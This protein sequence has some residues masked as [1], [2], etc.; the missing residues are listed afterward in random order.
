MST[1]LSPSADRKS[2]PLSIVGRLVLGVLA[3][4]AVYTVLWVGAA[5]LLR[6]QAEKWLDA[7]RGEGVEVAYHEPTLNGFP[8]QVI[9][10]FPDF[11]ATISGVNS[12][13]TWHTAA[14]R[15]KGNPLRAD[16]LSLDLAGVHSITG[17]GPLPGIPLQLAASQADLMLEIGSDGRLTRAQLEASAA[18]AAWENMPTLMQLEQAAVA[19]DLAAEQPEVS[20]RLSADL[21]N[22]ALPGLALPPL[23]S[24]MRRLH[25]IADIQGPVGH[26]ALPQVLEAW[27]TAGGT[28]EFREFALDW[29]PLSVDGSGTIALDGDLQPMGVFTA[30]FRGFFDTIDVL[31]E[32]QL[33]RSADAAMARIVLGL[34]ARSPPGGGPP[35]L[36]LAVTAQDRKLY[37]GPITLM[38]IPRLTWPQ[39]ATIP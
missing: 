13:W 33:V 2:K 6:Q 28:A 23:T 15:V 9:V 19:F 32:K 3:A 36:S 34:L 22:L 16:R 29:P 24:T 14:V 31:V 5:L 27:R 1:H 20:S 10:T 21:I 39:D 37:A 17:P 26:G 8:G 12:K 25:V 18:T 30:R 7:R 11:S 38:E 35:V 4:A